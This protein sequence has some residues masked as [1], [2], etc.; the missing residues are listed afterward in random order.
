MAAPTATL[1]AGAGTISVSGE[2]N[3]FLVPIDPYFAN[4]RATVGF[5]G[6]MTSAVVAV[7]GRL[8]GLTNFYPLVGRGRTTGQQVSNSVAVSLVNSTA[9]AF[10]FDVSQCDAI[11]IYAVSGTLTDL[12]VEVRVSA[13]DPN[14]MPLVVNNVAG[15][16]SFAGATTVTVGSATAL[17][18]GANG[19]TNPVLAVNTNTGSVA[20][21]LTIIGAAA[22]SGVA[23]TVL[24]SGTD[25]ALAVNA[26]GTGGI[27]LNATATGTV[28]IGSSLTVSA[29]NIIT[30]TSTGTKIGTATTQ[31]LG[32]F[33]ATPIVQPAAN[34][35][36]TTGAAGSVTSVFLNT[37]FS[38]AGGSAGYSI[39]GVVTAL[40]ALGLLAP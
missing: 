6:T 37:T 23:L 40:K 19:A 5:S 8:R 11:E 30:D 16:Q 1:T 27:S 31:K 4:P 33:N 14:D 24:S 3:G 12:D 10:E 17:T 39:G 25:E 2:D 22:A 18:V 7:R 15:N 29:K 32:F 35:D 36:T 38:G 9:A 20:T 13:A 21:G 34:T 26:K 28:T